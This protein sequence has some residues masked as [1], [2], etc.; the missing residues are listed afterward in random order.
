[1]SASRE[2]RR[3]GVTSRRRSQ[4]PLSMKITEEATVEEGNGNEKA[5]YRGYGDC[6]DVG[7]RACR[8]DAEAGGGD[9]QPGAHRDAE[10]DRLEIR[11][12]K[13]W[14]EGRDHIAPLGRGVP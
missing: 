11:G 8:H 2:P 14:H 12:G 3:C 10:V 6:P 13:P 7:D 4:L 1:M 5:S 9:H